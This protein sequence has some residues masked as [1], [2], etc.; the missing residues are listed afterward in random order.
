MQLSRL[1][2]V[3]QAALACACALLLLACGTA[4]AQ[5][6]WPAV[7]LPSDAAV[8]PV[9]GQMMVGGLPVR[10]QSFLLRKSPVEAADWFRRS[11]GK[12][13]MEDMVGDK[14][15]LGRGEGRFYISV[16]LE[17]ASADG[18]STRGTV[19]VSDLQEAAEKRD[20]TKALNDR[21]LSRLPG[22]TKLLSQMSS[23]DL[24]K[25]SSYVVAENGHSETL[26]RDRLVETMRADGYAL[27]R[28][29]RLDEP[30]AKALPDPMRRG[31]T[32]FFK[33]A[34]KEA[35]AVIRASGNGNTSIVLNTVTTMERVK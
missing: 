19:A 25:L 23:N 28:E 9:G 31:R 4:A 17:V 33:G 16:Q 8:F 27:E 35:L 12:P 3:L 6:V 30:A 14:L 5:P 11:L 22:G 13:L 21:L 15:V 29:G 2:A 20:S 26:N 7:N 34:G 10:M 32:L 18:K 1:N 24:G